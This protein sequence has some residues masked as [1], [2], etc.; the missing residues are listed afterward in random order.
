MIFTL[1]PYKEPSTLIPI[2]LY[3]SSKN[4][5]HLNYSVLN[6]IPW[7]ELFYTV[8]KFVE[9]KKID[10]ILLDRTG[11]PIDLDLALLDTISDFEKRDRFSALAQT[12]IITEDWKYWYTPDTDNVIWF[13]Y[14]MW[15]LN[16]KSI[17]KCY[18]YND[19]VY[20]CPIK[21]TKP[22]MCL[23]R[24]KNWHR[25]YLLSK[26]FKKP[27]FKKINYSYSMD[28]SP[29]VSKLQQFTI[30]RRFTDKEF[31]F[32][33][34]NIV[35]LTPI[36]LPDE[37]GPGGLDSFSFMYNRGASSV[38]LSV[39]KDCAI[40]LITETSVNEGVALTEKTFKAF[41]AYQI[42]VIIGPVGAAQ[43]L[44]DL[45]FDMFSDYV[46]WNLWETVKDPKVKIDLVVEWIDYVMK[47][48]KEILK[49]HKELYPRLIANHELFY[50][51]TLTEKLVQQLSVI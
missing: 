19:T 42:P 13:S 20:T 11:D 36:N 5:L 40:N 21:K 45:G 30:N 47:K 4:I 39:Y 44:E 27:W 18:D 35:P 1:L 6:E 7:N 17:D 31:E 48:P 26:I 3:A 43:Y 9:E 25:I 32:L 38:D 49:V 8:E 29:F 24:N 22:M 34:K 15:L 33:E 10:L 46:P 50:S 12:R 41:M 14:N 2:E 51:T 16:T 28:I 23:N 37:T